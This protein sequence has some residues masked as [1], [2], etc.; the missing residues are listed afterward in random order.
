MTPGLHEFPEKL[1]KSTDQ[2][3]LYE[4]AKSYSK[5]I[6]SFPYTNLLFNNFNMY[7]NMNLFANYMDPNIKQM[8][9][10]F[11]MPGFN[12]NFMNY[13][14]GFNN[15]SN[16]N[17]NS[18]YDLLKQMDMFNPQINN[19]MTGKKRGRD[20]G[21]DI[22]NLLEDAVGINR[23]PK[24]QN[25]TPPIN[26]IINPIPT[27]N[28]MGPTNQQNQIFIINQFNKNK[29]TDLEKT[30][31]DMLIPKPVNQ[32]IPSKRTDNKP[33]GVNIDDKN[34]INNIKQNLKPINKPDQIN[35]DLMSNLINSMLKV[36]P[37]QNLFSDLNKILNSNLGGNMFN[38]N[39]PQ[40]KKI[41]INAIGKNV[42]NKKCKKVI[43]N[44]E[45][46]MK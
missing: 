16:Y 3:N 10:G 11:N 46:R 28:S 36:E 14:Y 13:N 34:L 2:S 21:N 22:I 18:Y 35:N 17:M 29:M 15:F 37:S 45:K 5:N 38:K 40:G 31:L 24:N 19:N 20:D 8:M 43:F 42:S 27:I 39:V 4:M 7:D 41:T 30:L 6:A 1:L 25:T 26:P 33:S 9:T 44:I 23:N 12:D 32:L